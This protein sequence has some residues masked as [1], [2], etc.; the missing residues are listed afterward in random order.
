MSATRYDEANHPSGPPPMPVLKSAIDT[1]SPAFRDNAS[2]MRALVGDLND[3][4]A[5]VREGGGPSARDKHLAR[6]KLLPR[7]RIR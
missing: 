1:R 4:I 6:G 7:D 5:R 3:R 2:A